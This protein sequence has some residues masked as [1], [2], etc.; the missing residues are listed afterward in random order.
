MISF[1]QKYAVYGL[2]I[3]AIA[4]QVDY[5]LWKIT[6]HEPAPI[7]WVSFILFMAIFFVFSWLMGIHDMAKKE[8]K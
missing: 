7:S 6:N 3:F 8:D 5:W 1:I 2:A 4:D